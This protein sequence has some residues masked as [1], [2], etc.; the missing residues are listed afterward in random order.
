MFNVKVEPKYSK[1]G[2]YICTRFTYYIFNIFIY[3]VESY[4]L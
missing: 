2:K 1:E 3:A 4:E